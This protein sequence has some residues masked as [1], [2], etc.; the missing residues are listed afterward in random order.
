[1][2]IPSSQSAEADEISFWTWLVQ[3]NQLVMVVDLPFVEGL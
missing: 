3:F 2:I 1:M